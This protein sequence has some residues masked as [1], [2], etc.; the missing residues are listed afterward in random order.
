MADINSLTQRIFSVNS[1]T[2]DELALDIFHFQYQ[3]NEVYRTYTDLLGKDI[4]AVNQ[5]D[6]IP[7]LPIEFFKSHNV[8]SGEWN[9][10]LIFESSGTSDAITSEH[11]VFSEEFYLQNC[12][13]T[14]EVKYGDLS[15][16]TILALLPSY[17][18]RGNSGLVSMV[19]HFINKTG[20]SDSGFFLNEFDA[21]RERLIG[22]KETGKKTILWGVTFALLDFASSHPLE[23]PELIV[24][25]TGGMKGRRKEMIRPDVHRLLKTAFKTN[26]LHS[27]Y[28]MT[29]LFSQAYARN[30]GIFEPANTMKVLSRDLNDPLDYPYYGKN[31]GLNIIDLANVNTCSFI[32]TKDLGM[33]HMDGTFEVNGRIDNSEMRGC[34]L[35]LF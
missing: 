8:K 4:N 12:F 31:G 24:M 11:H 30:N 3:H 17:L 27:E 21:L 15:D 13:T 7:F 1:S 22:L 25:E 28:G 20:S 32:E 19:N 35:M 34:N 33:V 10:E 9:S 14:F 2:F 29:E 23:F 5:V 6:Q 16:F 26:K 18:E